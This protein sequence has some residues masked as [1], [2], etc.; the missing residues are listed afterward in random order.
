MKYKNTAYYWI[1]SDNSVRALY[2]GT[3]TGQPNRIQ[4]SRYRIGHTKEKAE[5]FIKNCVGNNCGIYCEYVHDISV[6]EDLLLLILI[7]KCT[8]AFNG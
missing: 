7:A 5:S 1:D 6:R 8:G 2:T 4:L 3:A